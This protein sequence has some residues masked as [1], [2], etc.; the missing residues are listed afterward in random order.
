MQQKQMVIK[1]HLSTIDTIVVK[2]TELKFVSVITVNLT[3]AD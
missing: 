2:V 1:D 3:T